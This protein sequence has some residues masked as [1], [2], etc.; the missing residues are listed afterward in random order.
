MYFLLETDDFRKPQAFRTRL[1]TDLAG[2]RP[3]DWIAGRAMAPSQERFEIELWGDDERALAEVFLESV[4]LFRNDLLEIIEKSGV[5]NLQKFAAVLRAP[6][7]LEV[8]DYSVVNIQGLVKCADLNKSKFRD[9]GGIGA[10]AMSFRKLVI[11]EVAAG[12]QLLFR[13]GEAASSIIVHERVKKEIDKARFEYL[14][15]RPLSA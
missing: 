2:Y 13:L 14:S 12:G 9:V 3:T 6:S 8:T 5:D 1:T 11:D 7:G 4:P 10:I 15:W